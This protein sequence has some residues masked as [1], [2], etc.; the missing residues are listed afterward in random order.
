M[1]QLAARLDLLA[2]IAILMAVMLLAM[3]A[4]RPTETCTMPREAAR[5]LI[6]TRDIDREHLSRDRMEA[7]R[8]ERRYT[9]SQAR[10]S[11]PK[12]D[13]CEARLAREI[14]AMHGVTS[15]QAR[16]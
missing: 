10:S 12:L 11:E 2:S 1:K 8:I 13:T 16:R 14:T 7:G 6:L 5:Q 15:E 4:Q 9:A 3:W